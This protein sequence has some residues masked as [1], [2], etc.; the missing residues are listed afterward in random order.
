MNA[1]G[2]TSRMSIP[3]DFCGRGVIGGLP[4]DEDGVDGRLRRLNQPFRG[5]VLVLE[6]STLI[7]CAHVRSDSAGQW[8]VSGLS[9]NY[10]YMVIG[11]DARGEV[12]SAIQDWVQP[13]VES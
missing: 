8:L 12:N 13:Y 5:Q 9:P 2:I 4:P 6:R 3:I 1:L 7:C 11:I 10:R